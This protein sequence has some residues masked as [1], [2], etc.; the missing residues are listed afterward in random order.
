MT[1]AVEE[2][3]KSAAE[4]PADAEEQMEIQSLALGGGAAPSRV[5]IARPGFWKR[6]ACC[7]ILSLTS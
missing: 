3:Q 7:L 4:P 5:L 6:L 2:Q 1:S